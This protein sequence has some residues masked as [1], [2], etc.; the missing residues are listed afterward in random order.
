MTH[1]R[2]G[3]V[4]WLMAAGMVASAGLIAPSSAASPPSDAAALS[5]SA[6]P[7]V[8]TAKKKKKKCG[9][10][11]VRGRETYKF[12]GPAKITVWV[13]ADKYRVTKGKCFFDKK[14]SGYFTAEI[15]I[16]QVGSAPP[17]ESYARIV[18]NSG[19]PVDNTPYSGGLTLVVP[20][21]RFGI[22]GFA[23]TLNN[24]GTEG[25]IE[26]LTTDGATV[27]ASFTCK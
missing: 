20:G 23:G 6:S 15:G 8:V 7:A 22:T 18:I 9:F 3:T 5:V 16:N 21:Q 17:T 13:G 14:N 25:K 11:R 4:A 27:R 12:C 1:S 26:A 10:M 19:S 2:F 24:N